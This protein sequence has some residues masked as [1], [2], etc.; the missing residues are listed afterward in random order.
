MFF[1]CW[2]NL[3][4]GWYGITKCVLLL[5]MIK[6]AGI[7]V[8]VF[9]SFSKSFIPKNTLSFIKRWKLEEARSGLFGWKSPSWII[10]QVGVLSELYNVC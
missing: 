8:A 3:L 1:G 10:A 2:I 6:S 7:H 5:V 9:S 4:N